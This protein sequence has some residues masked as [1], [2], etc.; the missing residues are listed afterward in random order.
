MFTGY[1]DE[2]EAKTI[3]DLGG[4]VVTDTED[5]SVL[6][7][8]KMRRTEKFL[9]MVG[10]GVPIVSSSWIQQSKLQ[11]RFAD[12]W[13][14]ILE[15]KENERK[16]GMGLGTT[17][18]LV[19]LRGPLLNGLSFHV[20]KNVV[21]TP[22]QFK[23]IIESA[24]GCYLTSAPKLPDSQTFIISSPQDRAANDKF[25]KTGFN[26]MDKEFVLSGLLK[27]KMDSSQHL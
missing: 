11:G 15:D 23:E 10:R 16:W 19:K 14:Y 3:Q 6:V 1:E 20:T 22:Q 13:S 18:V 7:T 8:D 25:R 26:V 5:C 24:G 12:P 27:Y 21:P 2:K 4:E 9:C 17:L